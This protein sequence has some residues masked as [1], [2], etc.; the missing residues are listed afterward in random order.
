[1][2]MSSSLLLYFSFHFLPVLLNPEQQK[3]ANHYFE[4][5]PKS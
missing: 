3:T 5:P 2:S 4:V 1:M